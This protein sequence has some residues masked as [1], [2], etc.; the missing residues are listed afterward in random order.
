MASTTVRCDGCIEPAVMVGLPPACVDAETHS[1]CRFIGTCD[2][3]SR[4]EIISNIYKSCITRARTPSSYQRPHSSF[5]VRAPTSWNAPAYRSKL[6]PFCFVFFPIFASPPY[7]IFVI[8]PDICAYMHVPSRSDAA[9]P[10]LTQEEYT[11]LLLCKSQRSTISDASWILHH[12][13]GAPFSSRS[14]S[15]TIRKSDFD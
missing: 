9:H 3:I 11:A 5:I 1:L 6:S 8:R 10:H 13:R 14:L 7:L 12:S 15:I 4:Q 2:R